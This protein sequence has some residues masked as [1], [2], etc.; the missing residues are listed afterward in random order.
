M[1][2]RFPI[3]RVAAGIVFIWGVVMM[4]TAGCRS[5]HGLY[6]QRFFLGMIE[7]GVSPMFMLVVSGFY[8]KHEQA[9]RMGIWYSATGYVSIFSPLINYG[10]GHITGG[11]LNS[12]Q[13]MYLVAGALTILWSF[14]ILFFMPPDPIR[15]RGFN[16]RQRYIAVARLRVNNAGVRNTHFKLNQALEVLYDPRGWLVFSMAFLL[17]IGNGPV[18]TFTPIIISSFG[19]SPLNSLLLVM[20]AGFII[21]T[22]EWVAP[23]FCYKF[24]NVRTYAIVVC[25]CGTILAAIL[26]WQ[27]PLDGSA[28]GGLLYAVFTLPCLGGTYAVLMGLQTANTAGGWI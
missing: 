14:V 25:Q 11:S 4:S 21:G 18:S 6:A 22:I 24:K 7:S 9:L 20:P 17:M 19:F 5:F 27:L 13:Y 16:D 23:W 15:V 3:E 2:Q 10:L 8:Q 12:W 1:A 28:T 26:L